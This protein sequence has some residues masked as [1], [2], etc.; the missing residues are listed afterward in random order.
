MPITYDDIF[1]RTALVAGDEMVQRLRSTRVLIV[2]VG[3]VG[4]W[5]A[6]MLVRSGIGH[7]TIV[8]NDTVAVSNINRQLPATTATVGRPKVDVLA[9]RF[10]QIN[11][12][13]SIEAING[14]YAPE[15]ADAFDLNSFDFVIDAIDTLE[16]KALLILRA[17][18]STAKLFSSMGAARKLHAAQVATAEFWKV[19]G[20]P[21]ARA[22]RQ[23]FKRSGE[24][25]KSKFSCVYSPETI[26]NR[27]ETEET[28]NAA[29]PLRK[30]APNG[31][32]AHTTALFGLTLAGLVVE[33]LY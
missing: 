28:G 32:F 25:P 12:E 26:P 11:P 2:G 3:G 16:C 23:R 27:K 1:A 29:G 10:C 18:A 33:E 24:L 5:A 21:L 15:T 9:E 19:E 20:C 14:V 30:G 17:S 8:D 13:L 4:S 22:L 7:I 6:E 31:T